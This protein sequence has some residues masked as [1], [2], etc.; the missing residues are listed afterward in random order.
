MV[1]A[2]VKSGAGGSSSRSAN[3]GHTLPA[4][5]PPGA[6]Q[7]HDARLNCR[8]SSRALRLAGCLRQRCPR[9]L[10][11][12]KCNAVPPVP[13]QQA[14]CPDFDPGAP[15]V[16]RRG[17]ASWRH[18]QRDV[19]TPDPQLNDSLYLLCPAL[20]SA[21]PA[22]AAT[23]KAPVAPTAKVAP[24]PAA[25]A[26]A[27]GSAAAQ[28]E[29]QSSGGPTAAMEDGDIFKSADRQRAGIKDAVPSVKK[30]RGH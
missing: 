22:A 25:K 3:T 14:L 2:A 8:S 24:P 20:C 28:L 30:A 16:S 9:L 17:N 10:C 19:R 21:P 4:V 6:S 29:R 11:L 27:A 7:P 13:Q 12:A 15:C 26:T 1:D 23:A 5:L 18:R